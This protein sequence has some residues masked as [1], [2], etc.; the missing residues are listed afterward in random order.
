MI[1]LLNTY[2]LQYINNY[3]WNIISNNKKKIHPHYFLG[4]IGC[5]ST[6]L[7]ISIVFSW[8]FYADPPYAFWKLTISQLG[9]IWIGD[10]DVQVV[11]N[12][13]SQLLFTVGLGFCSVICF[14]LTFMAL[15]EF[16]HGNQ[17]F[18]NTF[19]FGTMSI[20]AALIAIPRDHGTVSFLHYIGVGLFIVGFGVFNAFAQLYRRGR[21]RLDDDY[22]SKL[23]F[24]IVW[25]VIGLCCLYGFGFL[26]NL[27]L[28]TPILNIKMQ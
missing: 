21:K 26:I 10:G 1:I 4:L 11:S 8:I 28:E 15:I 13:T 20:G 2:K 9:G 12:P 18:L 16:I 5:L 3:W 17:G 19:L 22:V 7:L 14:I 24:I 6:A 23:D 27:I 25:I